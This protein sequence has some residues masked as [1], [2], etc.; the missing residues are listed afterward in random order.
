MA[1]DWSSLPIDLLSAIALELET[2]EGLIYFSAVCRSWNHASSS[3]KHLWEG[4]SVPWLLLAEK[5]KE[6]PDCIR[7]IFNLD[8]NKCYKLNLPETFGARCWGSPYGCI[9]MVG[10]DLNVQLF[11]PITKVK[12]QF[13]SCETVP[14]PPEYFDGIRHGED[15][16]QWCLRDFVNKLI[17]IKVS[18]DDD[19]EFVIAILYDCHDLAFARHGDQSWAS[20]LTPKDGGEAVVDLVTVNNCVLG[21][22]V[23]GAILFW[24]A[25]ELLGR[26]LVK[27]MKF[28]PSNLE[29]FDWDLGIQLRYFVHSGSDFLMVIRYKCIEL[30]SNRND[31][32]CD[33]VFQTCQF[34]VYK[35]K[36]E[37]WEETEDIGSE[38]LFVGCNQ[39]M[40]VSVTVTMS[41]CLQPNCIYFTNDRTC[42]WNLMTEL[43][44]YDMGVYDIKSGE[45]CRFYEG[46]DTHSSFCPPIWFA[47]DF[48]K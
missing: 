18:Q 7:K 21:L 28:S 3:I 6:N 33:T 1:A 31:Y 22:C 46:D 11:N 39:S 26:E 20:V 25:N 15:Y 42:C 4:D 5:N 36:G 41:E 14:H 16:Y 24:K 35:L 27:P 37:I 10:R 38:A 13:P 48:R 17:V 32:D 19:H 12:L 2:V 45:I 29:N 44:G 23:D 9:A 47:P 30:N 40:S 43:G 34:E 8:N